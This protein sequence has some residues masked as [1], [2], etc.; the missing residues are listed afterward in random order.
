MEI[1]LNKETAAICT[2]LTVQQ[3]IDKLSAITDKEQIVTWYIPGTGEF[4]PITSDDLDEITFND[5][6]GASV[7]VNNHPTLICLNSSALEE[8]ETEEGEAY[9]S[10]SE[11]VQNLATD[12]QM[13]GNLISALRPIDEEFVMV[14]LENLSAFNTVKGEAIE[15]LHAAFYGVLHLGDIVTEA[16]I[17]EMGCCED[18]DCGKKDPEPSLEINRE[19]V[20]AH[21]AKAE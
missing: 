1:N 18:C 16:E 14:D 19:R 10:I 6:S 11:K 12:I 8:E 4:R 9:Y 5:V 20:E 17:D 7:E 21:I 13:I 3:I 2:S 15:N